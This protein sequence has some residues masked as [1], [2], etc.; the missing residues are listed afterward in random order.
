MA[1]ERRQ[2]QMRDIFHKQ[3]EDPNF[4]PTKSARNLYASCT[5]NGTILAFKNRSIYPKIQYQVKI[6]FLFLLRTELL[7]GKK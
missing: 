7:F 6:L 4:L 1:S 5:E 3:D 2:I